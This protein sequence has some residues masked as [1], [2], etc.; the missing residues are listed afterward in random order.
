MKKKV[1][2]FETS[3][4]YEINNKYLERRPEPTEDDKAELEYIIESRK[5]IEKCVLDILMRESN[6]DENKVYHLERN[7]Y[8]KILTFSP[9][10]LYQNTSA[11]IID[12]FRYWYNGLSRNM[13]KHVDKR[14]NI[15][16]E[17]NEII[18]ITDKLVF[19]FFNFISPL[20]DDKE[21]LIRYCNLVKIPMLSNKNIKKL[22]NLIY[23][24]R[25]ASA[26]C[27]HKMTKQEKRKLKKLYKRTNSD[28]PLIYKDTR[29]SEKEN[30]RV[31]F[32]FSTYDHNQNIKR[33]KA[34]QKRIHMIRMKRNPLA[35]KDDW[36]TIFKY[37]LYNYYDKCLEEYNKNK[38]KN[39]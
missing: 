13:H 37:G 1:F 31:R 3:G 29:S 15:E 36:S 18:P 23:K 24:W 35:Y 14:Y 2:K 26:E 32:I 11:E 33:I 21:L 12:W 6:I 30:E 17:I 7:S 20:L 16:Y 4:V 5:W 9:Y 34:N 39:I 19:K 38:E 8:G 25:E 10:T 28:K 27:H 22:K